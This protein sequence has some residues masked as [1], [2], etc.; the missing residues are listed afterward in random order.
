MDFIERYLGFSPDDGDGPFEA[1][2]FGCDVK[3][4]RTRLW[5]TKRLRPSTALFSLCTIL[6]TERLG[7]GHR[8]GSHNA[9]LRGYGVRC[10]KDR[11]LQ[12]IPN[13]LQTRPCAGII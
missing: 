5:I 8:F 4:S 3:H 6:L 9:V 11:L 12:S 7:C 13:F 2:V 10:Y 1:L